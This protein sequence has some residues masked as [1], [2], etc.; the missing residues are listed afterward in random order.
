MHFVRRLCSTLFACA[1]I[2]AVAPTSA[3]AQNV[4]DQ[5]SKYGCT[6]CHA[7]DS[8]VVGPSFKDVAAKY[9]GQQ[10]AEKHLMSSVKNG[11]SGVWGSTPM[12]PNPTVSDADLNAM[13]KWI[14]SQK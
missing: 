9:R 2:S 13:L 10:G 3:P 14:L 6:A 5:F 7:V 8:K 11:S 12:P 4:P 1:A